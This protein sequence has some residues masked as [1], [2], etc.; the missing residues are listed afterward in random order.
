M[1][2]LITNMKEHV[3]ASVARVLP[4]AWMVIN[5]LSRRRIFLRN[6]KNAM[7]RQR[8]VFRRVTGTS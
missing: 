4:V 7:Y 6:Q 2:V 8:L 1:C 5:I 3:L